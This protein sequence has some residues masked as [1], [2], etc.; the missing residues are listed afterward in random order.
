MLKPIHNQD[1]IHR[2]EQSLE[3]KDAEIRL[4]QVRQHQELSHLGRDTHL[5]QTTVQTANSQTPTRGGGHKS[6]DSN[7]NRSKSSS[8]EQSKTKRRPNGGQIL[9]R[10]A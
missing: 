7:S 4:E 1:Q 10:L 8:S 5:Q 6:S 9:D 2:T 3:R